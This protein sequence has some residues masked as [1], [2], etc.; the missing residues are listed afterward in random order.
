MAILAA[1]GV[2]KIYRTGE[3]EV[4]ALRERGEDIPLLF[5]S[6]VERF[7]R[8]HRL[9]QRRIDPGIF[10]PLLAYSWPGNVRELKNLTERLVVFGGDSLQA[11]DLP[12]AFSQPAGS[13][14][15]EDTLE[16]GLLRLPEAW[17]ALSLRDFRNQCER[18][19]LEAVLRR[20]DWNF[21]AAARLLG[22]QRTYLH[23]KVASLGLERPARGRDREG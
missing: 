15:R 14:R 18:E 11:A 5:T 9:R 10:P 19:Y 12:A 23:Q 16:T 22:L 2:T 1:T 8:E 20:T 4:P 17:P 13:E 6:F 3:I 7:A 21:A